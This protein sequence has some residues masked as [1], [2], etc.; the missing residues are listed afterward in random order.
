MTGPC[1]FPA[2]TAL[3]AFLGLGDRDLRIISGVL[4]SSGEPSALPLLVRMPASYPVV[5]GVCGLIK[6]SNIYGQHVSISIYIKGAG[7][8][9]AVRDSKCSF[10]RSHIS[11]GR[12]TGPRENQ[13]LF[14]SQHLGLPLGKCSLFQVR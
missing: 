14:S 10:A 2:F 8:E 13:I 11:K 6:R 1:V 12:H 5:G 7:Y 9:P 4:R 3:G